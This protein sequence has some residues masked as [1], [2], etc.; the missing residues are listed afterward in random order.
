M[1]IHELK[2]KYPRLY[3]QIFALG[4]SAERKRAQAAELI[5]N[6]ESQPRQINP[7]ATAAQ[8]LQ[9]S[10]KW[11]AQSRVLRSEIARHLCAL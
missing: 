8:R 7:P 10:K 9:E 3:S 1:N 2:A 4:V 11:V 6:S 5:A